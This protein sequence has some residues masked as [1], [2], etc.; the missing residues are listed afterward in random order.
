MVWPRLADCSIQIGPAALDLLPHPSHPPAREPLLIRRY[1]RIRSLLQFD[2]IQPGIHRKT[3]VWSTEA[4]RS[5]SM[6]SRSQQL[7]GNW[8]YQRTAQRI[9][10]AVN[11]SRPTPRLVA[12]I[13]IRRRLTPNLATRPAS[14]FRVVL[15]VSLDEGPRHS[16]WVWLNPCGASPPPPFSR[17]DKRQGGRINPLL[18]SDS[19][20]LWSRYPIAVAAIGRV[21]RD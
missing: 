2:R 18:W 13:P 16:R 21:Y 3:V 1:G 11:C 20:S 12:P 9:T 4:P 8:R 10:S 6:S 5:S 7:I 19:A 15:S 17:A 14:A